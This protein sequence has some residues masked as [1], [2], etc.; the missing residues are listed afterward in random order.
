[1][2]YISNYKRF[3]EEFLNKLFGK[4]KKAEQKPVEQNPAKEEP[5]RKQLFRLYFSDNSQTSV[6]YYGVEISNNQILNKKI[7]QDNLMKGKEECEESFLPFKKV[8]LTVGGKGSDIWYEPRTSRDGE[9]E[10]GFFEINVQKLNALLKSGKLEIVDCEE[11]DEKIL[12][13][14]Q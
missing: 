8:G 13:V 3:N 9:D 6:E 2:K 4:D 11:P 14:K 10:L 12:R 7:E 5:A 1:M